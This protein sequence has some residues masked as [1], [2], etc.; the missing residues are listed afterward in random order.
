MVNPRQTVPT[1]HTNY[2]IKGNLSYWQVVTA[3]RL[4]IMVVTKI[5]L[6]DK[7]GWGEQMKDKEGWVEPMKDESDVCSYWEAGKSY[8][9]RSTFHGL[10]WISEDLPKTIKVSTIS[11]LSTLSSY[12]SFHFAY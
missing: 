1:N 7:E 9:G 5:S 4:V 6:S 10:S 3:R 2:T 8:L 12:H 11:D